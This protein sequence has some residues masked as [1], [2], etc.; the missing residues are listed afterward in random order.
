MPTQGFSIDW[1]CDYVISGCYASLTVKVKLTRSGQLPA[2]IVFQEEERRHMEYKEYFISPGHHREVPGPSLAEETPVIDPYCADESDEIESADEGR[3]SLK[4]RILRW[5]FP[6]VSRRRAKRVSV[7]GLVAYYWTGGAPHSY[8]VGNVSA[9]G[10]YLVSN[11]RWTPGTT[12]QMTLQRQDAAMSSSKE[13]I[14]VLSEVVRWGEDGAGFNFVL[15]D[16]ED[17]AHR[18]I[19]P[20]EATDRRAIERFI[21]RLEL[22][23]AI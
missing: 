9:T 3:V 1:A 13:T 4:I 18:Q 2:D 11:E 21:E 6:L 22:E 16:F 14:C 20:E 7:P 12:I 15:S 8:K 19:L 10:L 5:L 23:A 17:L